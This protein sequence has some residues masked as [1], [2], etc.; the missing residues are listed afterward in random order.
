MNIT[1]F[2]TLLLAE[3]PP[4]TIVFEEGR[5][6]YTALDILNHLKAKSNVPNRYVLE[7]LR[8]GRDFLKRKYDRSEERTDSNSS[9]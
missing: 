2:L 7:L 3:V 6:K 8:V 5:K 9:S 4:Y 1:E